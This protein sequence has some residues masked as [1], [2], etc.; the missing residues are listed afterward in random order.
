VRL[1]PN[2]ESGPWQTR[3]QADRAVY[4]SRLIHGTGHA[5]L[6]FM[7]VPNGSIKTLRTQG[8][9]QTAVLG[10][11][12]TEALEGKKHTEQSSLKKKRASV[13]SF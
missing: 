8:I 2:R 5:L 7:S 6:G 10:T 3:R 13:H 1:I 9:K 11:G 4:Y 12:A